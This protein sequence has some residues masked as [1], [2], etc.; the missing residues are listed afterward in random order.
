[1]NPKSPAFAKLAS[2]TLGII[3]CGALLANGVTQE[4]P[5]SAMNGTVTFQENGRGFKGALVTLSPMFGTE[6]DNVRT[7]VAE[8]DRDGKFTVRNMIAGEYRV[9]VSGEAHEYHDQRVLLLE[10][11]PL[12][13]PIVLKPME[14][15]LDVYAEQHV[16][17]SGE[18]PELKIK[19]FVEAKALDLKIYKLDF[20]KVIKE[21]SLYSALA[22]LSNSY[23]R[24]AKDP[25]TMGTAVSTQNHPLQNRDAEGIFIENLK[26]PQL[27]PGIYW[28]QCEAG[29]QTR[30]TWLNVTDIALVTK[31]VDS[32]VTAFVTDL[33]TGK[34]I[35]S[36]EVGFALSGKYQPL[37]KTDS[38]GLVQITLPDA[39][40]GKGVVMMASAMAS[41]GFV[42]FERAALDQ[43][44]QTSLFVYTDRPIY[45]PGDTVQFKAI[46]RILTGDK[47][48]LPQPGNATVELRDEND[49]LIEKTTLPVSPKGNLHGSFDLN[50]ELKPGSYN[51]R[52]AYQGNEESKNVSVA[53]YRKPQY[54]IKVTPEKPSY[55]RGDRVK[56]KVEVE[57]YFGGPV[58]GAKVESYLNRSPKWTYFDNEEE[59]DYEDDYSSGGEYV[60]DYSATTDSN[61]VATIEF[62]TTENKEE[63]ASENDYVYTLS[64]SVTDDA[65]QYFDGEGKVTVSRGEFALKVR[66]SKWIADPN[67][68]VEVEI[69]A[70]ESGTEKPIA[71]KVIDVFTAYEVWGSKGSA[72]LPQ[73]KSTVTTDSEGKAKLTVKGDKSGNFLVRALARDDRG[74]EVS[75]R[76]YIYLTGG[77]ATY[78]PPEKN[79]TVKLDK[80]V[81]ADGDTAKA[82]ITTDAPGGYVLVTLEG[83]DL[84]EVRSVPLEA[85]T[86][87]EFAVKDKYAPNVYVSVAYVKEKRFYEASRRLNLRLGNR[88]LDV[89]VRSDKEVYQP[90]ET[91]T[92]TVETKDADGNPVS[93]DV[94]LGV[95]DESIYALAQDSTNIV[96]S[97]YPRRFN[98]VSTHYS[99]P[100]IYLDGGDKATTE[101][102]IRRK[103][104][105]TAFWNPVV[106][107][108]STG[109]ATVSVPLPDNLTQ[110]R[111]TAIACSADTQV[112]QTI[113]RVKARKVLMVRLQGPA[114]L[115]GAD[116]QK[117]TAL[118][119]NDSGASRSVRFAIN[120]QGAEV[121]GA[122]TSEV[123]VADGETSSVDLTVSPNGTNPTEI[124]LTSTVQSEQV[125]D[126]VELKIPVLAT[127]AKQII[128]T[129]GMTNDQVSQAIEVS[130]QADANHGNLTIRIIPSPIATVT[131]RLEGLIDFPYGCVEQTM[132]RY[133][134]S[135]VAAG[136]YK[137]LGLTGPARLAE[138]PKI[139]RDSVERLRKMQ[140][141]KGGF[142]WWEFDSPSPFMTAYV[143][144]GFKLASENGYPAPDKMARRALDWAHAYLK[145]P[146]TLK[147]LALKEADANAY[148]KDDIVYLAYATSLY[149]RNPAT[150]AVLETA[151]GIK[152][153]VSAA[154]RALA[155]R[156]LGAIKPAE[157]ALKELKSYVKRNGSLAS[158]DYGWGVEATARA[159]YTLAKFGDRTLLPDAARYLTK[160]RWWSTR[161]TAFA[162]IGLSE[163]LDA[164][165]DLNPNAQVQVSLNGKTLASFSLTKQSLTDPALVLTVPMTDLQK[166]QNQ[167]EIR[168]TGTGTV[169]FDTE[170]TQHV[171]P[172]P[173]GISGLSVTRTYHK[174]EPQ[175][176][177]DG[178]VRLLPSKT[179]TTDFKP[180]DLLAVEV[181]V[182]SDRDR[183]YMLLEDP[184]PAGFRVTER[185]DPG[186]YETWGW[187]FSR[188]LVYDD[189]VAVFARTV[190]KGTQVIRYIMRAESAGQAKV[191]P[192]VI[193]NMYSPLERAY[194]GE[195][196][197]T[198]R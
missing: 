109:T 3:T 23:G 91:A 123:N 26:L 110:W 54:S 147:I 1:M 192:S 36:A 59:S 57:Y 151:V 40:K 79:I 42:D 80:R 128:T 121:T 139:A 161:D 174:L 8:C 62:P 24:K 187:W 108:D 43:K 90:G 50:S 188:L 28:T 144:E 183:E 142:G 160:E 177:E 134:P 39:S 157:E 72:E 31:Q 84:H 95:V 60:A 48:S 176:L 99:F 167:L 52:V 125:S 38:S 112:G 69:L 168:K 10:G 66:S 107:T 182:N 195:L 68:D 30:G 58:I 136:L 20:T 86:V 35:E 131:Q 169:Y 170:L 180:G 129:S 21:G 18:A 179:A 124:T 143:L 158:W 184:I 74:N 56:M 5:R 61:G 55:R 105:D 178:S 154:Y 27:K 87:V 197:V 175:P 6:D 119:T 81:Y 104:K 14:P 73:G 127:G 96:K 118:I 193:Y 150:K 22:P 9:S 145:D 78:G 4:V 138:V 16:F 162:I 126:G 85:S 120:A 17:R 198:V 186:E 19:G 148:Q 146:E 15:Y 77:S 106:A 63:F 37:G 190:P 189:R 191:R 88:V 51:L 76:D 7:R 185:E 13:V 159:V 93:A 194:G 113:Q 75:A 2:L 46:A 149:G 49:D 32:K 33:E 44:I 64:A 115:T 83:E 135:V 71:N 111:A 97:F 116:Q 163:G 130:T 155:W 41:R 141:E 29:A 114:F 89:Q 140:L 101:I 70:T 181:Q 67:Q 117:V 82:L 53:A 156:N 171:A 65:G 103:F 12:D 153:P 172:P 122:P 152:N 166:G 137:K 92:Y 102:Q 94:S 173:M 98:R 25:A 47:Y 34:P 133:M 165:A 11:K 45:R 164:S 100:D 196:E 132:S